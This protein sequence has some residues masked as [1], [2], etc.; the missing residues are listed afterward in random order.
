MIVANRLS[1][2]VYSTSTSLLIKSIPLAVKDAGTTTEQI[3][4]YCLS[5]SNPAFCWVACSDGAVFRVDWTSGSGAE[6]Y[7]TTSSTGLVTITVASMLSTGRLRDVVFTTEARKE[8]G[9]RISTHE[10]TRPGEAVTT[11]AKTIFTISERIHD[12]K[13]LA[14]GEIIVAAAEKKVLIGSLR[15]SDFNTVDNIKYQFHT[16][17]LADHITSLDARIG[18]LIAPASKKDQATPKKTNSG[19][20]VVDMAVGDAKGSIFLYSDILNLIRSHQTILPKKLHWHRKAVSSIKWSRDGMRYLLDLCPENTELT[21][22]Q[23]IIL[24][25]EA[26]KPSWSSGNSKQVTRNSFPICLLKFRTLSYL[27]AAAHMRSTLPITP[28]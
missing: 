1:L 6:E 27:L 10:L 5:P 24:S 28:P 26:Q 2:Q 9:Y 20:F 25:Q 22:S 18:G 21:V 12:M 11:A 16:F 8:G 15:S 3:V 14:G 17:E 13:T 4:A 7:W 19:S 23:V